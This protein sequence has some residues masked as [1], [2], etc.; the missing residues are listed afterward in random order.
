VFEDFYLLL[1]DGLVVAWM[2]LF[3]ESQATSDPA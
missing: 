3:A 2:M 1:F